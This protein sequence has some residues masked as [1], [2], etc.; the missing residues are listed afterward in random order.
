[1]LMGRMLGAISYKTGQIYYSRRLSNRTESDL[2]LL[3]LKIHYTQMFN[4][5]SDIFRQVVPFKTS[6]F[7][8]FVNLGGQIWLKVAII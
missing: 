2:G 5:W 1:M 3:S 8:G 7:S 6:G 4:S